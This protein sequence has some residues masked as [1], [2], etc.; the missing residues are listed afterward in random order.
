MVSGGVLDSWT[1][2][3]VASTVCGLKHGAQQHDV[4]VGN[5]GASDVEL[6]KPPGTK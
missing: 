1:L 5:V 4:G 6:Q 2:G 3:E